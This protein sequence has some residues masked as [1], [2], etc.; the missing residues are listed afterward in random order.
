MTNSATPPI[1]ASVLI[2]DDDANTRFL[3]RHF[4]EREGY[5]IEEAEDGI[6]AI[7]MYEHL[8][9]SI[10]LLDA[11]MPGKDGFEV[12]AWLQSAPP[13]ERTPVL[14][15]TGLEDQESVDRAFEAG[16]VDYVTKPIHW[17]V[18]RQRLRRV[19]LTRQLE[20]LRDDLTQMIVH[21][22]KNPISTIRG[23]AQVLLEDPFEED[24]RAD[25]IARIY[26]SSTKLLDMT[27]MI[28]D[29]GRLEENKLVLQ[30][31]ERT[32]LE[33]FA[34]V[35]DSFNWV[36]QDRQIRLEIAEC[37]P[38]LSGSLDW[39]LIQRVLANL[40]SNAFKH[41]PAGSSVTLSARCSD[42]GYPRLYLSVTDQGEGIA[43]Q[44]RARIFEK[45]TQATH[46]V[47]GSRTDTGLGLTFSKLA[48]EA[49]GGVIELESELGVGSRF[50]LILPM[51]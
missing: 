16:A 33:V 6:Q 13:S 41:S 23:Y 19:I 48:T 15:I 7:E 27:M 28:L 31:S 5:T 11:V 42:D 24:W 37:D 25:A 17:A 26:H 30:R 40:I 3:L 10:V 35:K 47:G 39:G 44:D 14:M 20:K 29:I 4:L 45:F 8:R 32:V 51:P 36:A 50:T 1:N 9:P 12:C 49:H 46:R 38:N 22:M 34:E 2:V 43:M 21:D 18:L